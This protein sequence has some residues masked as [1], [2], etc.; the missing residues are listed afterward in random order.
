VLL[1]PLPFADPER[2]VA[3]YA[4]Q[5]SNGVEQSAVSYGAFRDWKEQARSYSDIAAQSYRSLSVTDGQV[6]ERFLGSAVT[7]NLF[8]LLGVDPILGRHFTADDD[9]AGGAP[10]VILSH[11]VWQRRYAGDA[12]VLGRAITV[13]G[14]SHTVIGVM[15][16]RFQF[17]QL[18]QLWIPLVPAEQAS[19][20]TQRGVFPYA[21]LAD[22]ATSQSASRELAAIAATLE[23]EHL[24]DQGW[25]ARVATM[26]DDLMPEEVRIASVA[27]MGGVAM[28]LLI[29][30]AN[31]ANLLLARATARQ[32]EIAVRSAIGAG[33]LRI[34]RQLLTE[35]ILLGALAA[36][37]GVL[38]GYAGLAGIDAAT[39]PGAVIPYYVDWSMN[40]RVVLYTIAISILTG[41][42]FGLAPALQ[43]M[44]TDLA[45]ALKDGGRGSGGSRAR[46]RLRKLL[47]VAEVA[48]SLVLLVGASLF[49][50][51]HLEIANADAG[52]DTSRLM[53][54][55]VFMAD[56]RYASA[57]ER[58]VRID[59]VMRRVESLPGVEAAF[60]SN[61]VPLAAGG[62]TAAIAIDGVA[63]EP[64]REPRL[65]Y[66]G[67]TAQVV[68]AL[69][70]TLVAGREFTTAEAM[71]RSGVVLVNRAFAQRFWPGQSDVIG[72]RF[73]FLADPPDQWFSVLGVVNDF[74]P[75]RLRDAS[76]AEPLAIV[77]FPYQ[78]TRDNGITIRVAGGAPSA[79][80]APAREA[81][82]QSDS[83][84]A[85]YDAR[86]GAAN[87]EIRAWGPN[88][89]SKMFV[90]SYSVAQRTQEFGVRV[91]L[92]AS[93]QRILRLVLGDGLR[94]AA[95]GIA[96][97]A[98]GAMGISRL[99]RTLLY[100]VNDS[101]SLVGT[102]LLLGA[103]TMLAGLVPARRATSVDPIVALRA[104]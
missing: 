97:G 92:G 44:Q 14:T 64:G 103:V 66:F 79:I 71:T 33:R 42:V 54:L 8:P 45:G 47:V 75:V 6:S 17:P 27:M 34:V 57:E 28:V 89:L 51:S 95:V 73:R 11:G 86:T 31:V 9:R 60:A 100:N 96:V 55:R 93:K 59:D 67:A 99:I 40:S 39:P 91:A 3:L 77:P 46:N 49:V 15:P 52:V 50:Q 2:L 83:T 35:S 24:E 13:N 16:P 82:G 69:G 85:I 18:A 10:V 68:R 4:T 21:R 22:R 87:R 38:V 20:R 56:D 104:E 5:L 94:L 36:P 1:R 48:L 7:W 84:L 23:R 80:T 98:V 78:P 26:R 90:L 41:I 70:Q 19:P 61:L 25:S 74:Q 29:A 81:I 101:R 12:A 30:C 58:I 43:A 72:R 37:L 102:A 88:I 76:T 62:A 32:R 53:T 63:S 65:F